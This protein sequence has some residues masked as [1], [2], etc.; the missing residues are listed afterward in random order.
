VN[1]R[2]DFDPRDEAMV[3]GEALRINDHR[4]GPLERVSLPLEEGEVTDYGLGDLSE[5]R[6]FVEHYDDAIG[7]CRITSLL[8]IRKLT[9]LESLWH[10]V[11][12]EVRSLCLEKVGRDVS[13]LEPEPGFILGLR[14]LV[15]TL[16][17]QWAERH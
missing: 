12:T 5:L 13:E 15:R 17:H 8:P 2:G 9:R 16:A 1:L 4:F 3:S 6:R 10:E 14:A 7:S 11:E